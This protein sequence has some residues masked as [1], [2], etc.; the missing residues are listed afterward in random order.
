M[1]PPT[2]PAAPTPTPGTFREALQPRHTYITCQ[3]LTV[4]NLPNSQWMIKMTSHVYR[5]LFP[6]SLQLLIFL[7]QF[8]WL[9]LWTLNDSRQKAITWSLLACEQTMTLQIATCFL[10]WV[11]YLALKRHDI[12][13]RFSRHPEPWLTLCGQVYFHALAYNTETLTVMEKSM[14]DA[15]YFT[16]SIITKLQNTILGCSEVS[17]AF[18]RCNH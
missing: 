10:N 7:G 12:C 16:D 17:I 18:N 5:D 3:H 13:L 14:W 4:T 6:L 1:R 11:L 9:L 15:N 2:P 8:L